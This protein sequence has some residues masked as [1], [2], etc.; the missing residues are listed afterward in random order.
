MDRL[1]TTVQQEKHIAL[2]REFHKSRCHDVRERP[3][4][5]YGCMI[6]PS[7]QLVDPKPGAERECPLRFQATALGLNCSQ[8]L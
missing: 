3:E 5:P 4:V 1:G 6:M 2:I 7:I 8:R